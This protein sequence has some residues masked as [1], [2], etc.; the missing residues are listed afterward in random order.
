M[1][2]IV[3][4]V[5]RVVE[6]TYKLKVEAQDPEEAQDIAYDFFVE[7]PNG[8]VPPERCLKVREDTMK[9]EIIE[10]EF[11]RDEPPEPDNDVFDDGDE[12]A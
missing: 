4:N 3:V 2:E 5:K 1:Y 9:T 8:T 11:E 12:F 7:F 6:E 10:I